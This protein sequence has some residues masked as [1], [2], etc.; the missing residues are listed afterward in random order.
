MM[1]WTGLRLRNGLAGVLLTFLAVNAAAAADTTLLP[2]RTYTYKQAGTRALQLEVFTPSFP[3]GSGGYP[4]I[5]LFHGG[6]WVGGKRQSMEQECRYFAGRGMVAVTASYR[7]MDRKAQGIAG[8]KEICLRDAKSAIRWV[9]S[10]AAMLG[11][12]TAKVVLGGGSA[13]GHLATM[14]ALDRRVNDPQ[15]DTTIS[16]R[17]LALVLY[18]PA[19]S[20][21]EDPALQPFDK[22]SRQTPPAILFYG[23]GDTKWGPPGEQFY[24]ELKKRQVTTELWIAP[25]Q[26]HGFYNKP[27]WSL[28]TCIKADAFLVRLGILP[29]VPSLLRRY[30]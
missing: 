18:N 23:D 5:I 15:D 8:T 28:A 6:G 9:R 12:D 30:P 22:L 11:I 17:A 25:E 3:R 20:P 26:K 14:A 29:P 13:G 19:Y 24:G 4:V 1:S 27:E 16:T 21:G 2:F 10:H 7:F